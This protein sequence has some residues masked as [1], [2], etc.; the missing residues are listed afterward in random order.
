MIDNQPTHSPTHDEQPSFFPRE[1]RTECLEV[2][3][4]GVFLHYIVEKGCGGYGFEHTGRGGRYGITYNFIT[5]LSPMD[6]D[7]WFYSLRKSKAD[8]PGVDQLLTVTPE[9]LVACLASALMFSAFIAAG[10]LLLVL[11]LLWRGGGK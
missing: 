11:V 3:R 1:F 6:Y 4:R 5:T 10:M 8:C 7:I 9:P 2:R